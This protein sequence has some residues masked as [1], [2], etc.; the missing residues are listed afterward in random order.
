M[1]GCENTLGTLLP[2]EA[3]P[4]PRIPASPHPRD[5]IVQSPPG[6]PE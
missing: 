6:H 2:P 3:V 5:T 4:Y 1:R